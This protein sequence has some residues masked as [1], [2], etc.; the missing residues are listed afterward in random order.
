MLKWHF[1]IFILFTS[2]VINAQTITNP[3][4]T[5][6]NR[7]LN[8]VALAIDNSG[9]MYTA[10]Q[11]ISSV[12]KITQQ[13]VVTKF[14]GNLDSS[15]NPNAITIDKLGNI[16]TANKGNNTVSKITPQ[17]LVTKTWALLDTNAIPFAITIDSIGNIY[18]ANLGNNTVSKITPQGSIT[19][20][21]ANLDSNAAPNAI[22]IDNLGNVYTANSR[23]N[24]IS[25]ITPL[26]VVAKIW[27]NFSTTINYHIEIATDNLGNV[28]TINSG[29][30]SNN[31]NVYK[32]NPNGIISLLYTFSANTYAGLFNYKITLDKNQNIFVTNAYSKIITKIFNSGS[33]QNIA[34]LKYGPNFIIASNDGFFYTTN[35]GSVSK[36]AN[37]IVTNYDLSNNINPYGI[38]TDSLGNVF[39]INSESTLSKISHTISR[40][41]TNGILNQ[42]WV[43]FDSS[44]ISRYPLTADHSG[45]I[46]VVNDTT[47]YLYKISNST[48]DTSWGGFQESS[49]KYSTKITSDNFGN[50][51]LAHT[52][53]VVREFYMVSK[54][55]KEGYFR[56]Y[57]LENTVPTGPMTLCVDQFGNIYVGDSQRK[58]N[59]IDANGVIT[60]KWADYSVFEKIIADIYGN[61]YCTS[62]TSIRKLSS[63]GKLLQ[64]WDG[65][66]NIN[67]YAVDHLGNFY[68][69]HTNPVTGL[70]SVNRIDKN[71]VLKNN[72]VSGFKYSMPDALNNPN[73]TMNYDTVLNK[74]YILN[75]PNIDGTNPYI[76]KIDTCSII[77]STPIMT[78]SGKKSICAGDSAILIS[79]SL[80]GNKWYLNDTLIKDSTRATL[81][82]KIK[83]NYSLKSAINGCFSASSN[84]IDISINPA[85]TL[86]LA[87]DTTYC[88]GSIT[89][90]LKVIATT[91]NK[92]Q[93]YGTNATGG[94][95]TSVAIKPISNTNGGTNYYVSQVNILTGCEGPR[96][97]VN[98]TINPV[99]IAPILSRDVNN[100]LI[101]NTNGITWYKD[102]TTLQDTSQKFKPTLAGSYTAKTFLNGCFSASSAAYYYLV[103]DI[104]NISTDEYIKLAPNP[105]VNQLNFDFFLKGYQRLNMEVFDISSGAKVVS[106]Q[107]LTPGMPIYLGELAAGTYIIIVT[108]NDQKLSYQFKMVKL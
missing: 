62:S 28:Y 1:I 26:G 80:N 59:K 48:T 76:I 105:F 31:A 88:N 106:K 97:K 8:A 79:N 70:S 16:Y 68:F 27:A 17:G 94:I 6:D 86:P 60:Y 82:A 29:L 20:A 84:I 36:I 74:I 45:N 100:F 30:T 98:V 42:K 23:N 7:N 108:S 61:I 21:W 95:G 4:I 90:T 93:W 41:S 47:R 49:I 9:N 104:V 2:I 12:S 99:P 51:Y 78:L 66:T 87:K 15:A 73:H 57:V 102:G 37:S 103:T 81:L 33:V 107:N 38:V 46:F 40:I 101:A 75:N 25:K 53:G 83:G 85:P 13:G 58:I 55:S 89:D 54:F 71:G 44:F 77:P 52:Y 24:T 34:T 92:L 64:T 69:L 43:L 32:I 96:A 91:G 67:D 18:T 72:W 10:N 65:F 3:W 11:G 19:K 63:S 39:S 14:W 22:A 5:F 35:G 50:I 56:G